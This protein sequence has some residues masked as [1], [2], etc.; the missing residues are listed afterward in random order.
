[1][2][3]PLPQERRYAVVNSLFVPSCVFGGQPI[4]VSSVSSV[5][6]SFQPLDPIRVYPSSSAVS[7]FLCILCLFAA[8]LPSLSAPASFAVGSGVANPIRAHCR[9]FHSLLS[10]CDS[11]CLRRWRSFAVQFFS[12]YP[13]PSAVEP[14]SRGPPCSEPLRSPW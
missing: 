4:S 10:C 13:H 8:S 12:G 14:R 7:L 2:S 9:S 5:V 11:L 1:M 6:S 3:S